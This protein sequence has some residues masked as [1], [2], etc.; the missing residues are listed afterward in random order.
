MTPAIWTMALS[1]LST[2]AML[3][4]IAYQLKALAALEKRIEALL[5]K[6][7]NCDRRLLVIETEHHANHS[8]GVPGGSHAGFNSGPVGG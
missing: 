2:A 3:G 4:G 1:M 7:E 5:A 6:F 8:N